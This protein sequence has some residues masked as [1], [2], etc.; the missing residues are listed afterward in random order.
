VFN[1]NGKNPW[2]YGEGLNPELAASNSQSRT[3]T[4]R[5]L[6]NVPPY[7][8]DYQDT[9]CHQPEEPESHHLSEASTFSED[10]DDDYEYSS[11]DGRVRRGSEGPEVLAV[12]R[13]ELLRRYIA[14]RGEEATREF[15]SD[16]QAYIDRSG[17]GDHA[18]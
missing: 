1:L 2:T 14:T 4:R 17:A 12:D 10:S 5:G 7:H 18:L 6:T 9:D 3:M 13:E 15:H 11:H 16:N 8:P